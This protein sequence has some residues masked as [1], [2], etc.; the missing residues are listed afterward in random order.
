[1]S[2]GFSSGWR[3]T[4]TIKRRASPSW[5]LTERASHGLDDVVGRALRVQEGDGVH[6]ADVDYL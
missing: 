4:G 2:S 6:G 3:N 1:M 5:L